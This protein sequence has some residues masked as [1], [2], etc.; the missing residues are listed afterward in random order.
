MDSFLG[1]LASW[2]PFRALVVGD[3]MLDQLV[4]GDADRLAADSPVP[5]L[6]ARR[7][8][9]RPGGAANLCLDL[10]ALHGVV[11]GFGVTGDDGHARVL[12]DRLVA[13]GIGV[14]GLVA[15]AARPTTVKCSLIG[16][17]Q[18]RHVQKMFR[19]DYE[20]R[21]PLP[22]A[23]TRALLDAYERALPGTDAV[24]IEDYDRGVCTPETC[25][26]IIS[27]ARAR[28]LPVLVDPANIKNYSKYRGCTAITPN[29]FEAERAAGM[30]EAPAA[31]G[32][33]A[34]V[35]RRL[36]EQLECEAVILTLDRDGALLLERGREPLAIPTVARAVY[37]VTGAGDMFL[38]GLTAGRG[39]GLSWPDAVRLANAAAGLEVEVFGVVPM[40]FEKV[41]HEILRLSGR[42]P[43][44]VR[45]VE[46]VLIEAQ[47]VRQRGGKVVFT[48][49]CFDLLHA[50]HVSLLE[51]AAALGNFL[52]VGLNDDASI[53]RLKGEGRPVNNQD[54]RA[55]VLGGQG[56]VDAVVL[57]GEDTPI[58]L[59][60]MIS[61]DVLVKGADYTKDRVVGGE[62][63]ESKG[64]KVVLVDLV[65]GKSTTGTIERMKR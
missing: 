65:E 8:E 36:M 40:P 26:A 43:G 15:D 11:T 24:C 63:V 35:A 17:A 32:H 2:R 53:R 16:L 37:D 23:V 39:N 25:A 50:G 52:V 30:S 13:E 3:F 28:G 59:I 38:A 58:K 12:R 33:N 5:V 51:K 57:F 46:Q 61:P 19:V 4:F 31:D 34:A 64:G 27:L 14:A 6:A 42:L 20:S 22:A 56:S 62:L 49:G 48:N 21:D 9:E 54:D 29:R 44:K 47:A 1:T 18:H 7:T 55:R 41:H 10:A 45:T 60:E